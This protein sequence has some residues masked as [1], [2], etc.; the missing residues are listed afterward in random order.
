M[1][2]SEIVIPGSNTTY[3]L[4]HKLPG[5]HKS[6]ASKYKKKRTKCHDEGKQFVARPTKKHGPV[7]FC[8]NPPGKGTGK[9]ESA[10]EVKNMATILQ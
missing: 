7:G 5:V 8:R 4:K 10:E 2:K 6:G 9:R 1:V 3:K